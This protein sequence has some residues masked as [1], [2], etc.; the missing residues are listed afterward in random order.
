M[1]IRA[2]GRGF[3]CELLGGKHQISCAL[4]G[5][6]A[7]ET[8]QCTDGGAAQKY[9]AVAFDTNQKAVLTTCQLRFKPM[10]PTSGSTT[11]ANSLSLQLHGGK[12]DVQEL[13][14]EQGVIDC[15]FSFTIRRDPYGIPTLIVGNFIKC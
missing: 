15:C 9:G 7:G 8:K 5:R 6:T 3:G 2:D 1:H 12:D 11:P 10:L 14:K 13:A 4:N